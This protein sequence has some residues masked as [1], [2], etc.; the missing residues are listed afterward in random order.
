M[1]DDPER[2][3]EAD[4]L[5]PERESYLATATCVECGDT[6]PA[7]MMVEVRGDE[8]LCQGCGHRMDEEMREAERWL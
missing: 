8:G 2:I 4:I 5:D 7:A 6:E 3:T 1:M